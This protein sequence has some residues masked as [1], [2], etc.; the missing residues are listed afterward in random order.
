[1]AVHLNPFILI[2]RKMKLM[3]RKKA[4][5]LI[6]LLIFLLSSII[7]VAEDIEKKSSD[8]ISISQEPEPQ[9]ESEN[10]KVEVSPL[11]K[12][13][14]FLSNQT[15]SNAGVNSQKNQ[16]STNADPLSV[17]LGLIFI[18]IIIFSLAWFMKKM[19]YSHLS[20]QGQLKIVAS[21]NLGAKEKIAL[22]QVGDQQLLVGMTPTQINTLYVLDESITEEKFEL[23]SE[24]VNDNKDT[25]SQNPFANKLSEY[26]NNKK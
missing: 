20:K 16:T 8:L 14:S 21:L 3:W 1:M 11:E 6:T 15:T 5:S 12:R 24:Q 2:K 23:N 13:Y 18:L 17:S 25:K 26:L 9:Q 19:G 22:I 7:V 10:Q 4:L